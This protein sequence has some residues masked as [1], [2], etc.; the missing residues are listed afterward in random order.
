MAHIGPRSF[1][2]AVLTLV[3]LAGRPTHSNQGAAPIDVTITEGTSMAAAV[4]PDGE[5]VVID[6]QGSLWTLPSDGG[7]ATRIIDEFFDARQPSWSPDG[8]TIVFQSYRRGTWDIWAVRADGSDPTPLTGGAH[9]DREPHWS[10]DGRR[11]AFS[12]D[13]SGNYDLWMLD[14]ESGNLEQITWDPANDFAPAWSPDGQEIAFVSTRSSAPGIWAVTLGGTERLLATFD[15]TVNAPSWRPGT[16]EVAFNGVTGTTSALLLSDDRLTI[17]EDVF[18]FRASWL[19][20]DE[21]VYTADGLIKR[22]S[23][24]ADAPET[25]PFSASVTLDRSAYVRNHRDFDDRSPRQAFGIVK[26]VVS[27]DAEQVAFV[28]LGDLWLM[29]I[30]GRAERL[31]DD[32]FAE[33]DPAWSPDGRQL[34]F[35]SD[36]TGTMDLWVRDM[37]SGRERRLTDLPTA[38]VAAAWSPNGRLIAFK[39][40]DEAYYTV[41]VE[42]GNVAQVHAP[43]RR[44]GRP[45]WGPDGRTL[46]TTILEPYSSRY[47]EGTSQLLMMT[48]DGGDDRHVTAVP[49]RSVGKRTTDGPVWSPDGTMMALVMEGTLHVMA[50]SRRG[51]P[52]GPPRQLTDEV[53]DGPSWTGDSTRVLYQSADRLRMVSVNDGSVRDVPLD[54][55]WQPRAPTGRTVVH[56]GR[57]FDGRLDNLQTDVDIVIEAN[58]IRRVVPHRA[59][60]HDG[61]VIDASERTVMPGLI[62]MHTHLNPGFGEKLGR[63][64]LA[65]GITTVRIPAGSPYEAIESREAFAAGVRLGPRIYTTGYIF[66]GSRIFYNGSM[67][68]TAGPQLERELE[69]ARVMGYDLLKTYVRLPDLLQKRV[70][71]FGHRHGMPVT[72][73]ELYP[74]VAFGADGV[75]HIGGTSRR[76]YSPKRSSLGR[77]YGDVIELL[78]ASGM[79]ITPTIAIGGFQ[80]IAMRHPSL[81]ED[82]RFETL[83]P[84]WVVKSTRDSVEAARGSGLA[85]RQARTDA[86]AET[87]LALTRAGARIVAGTD[88]PIM[89]YAV[90]LHTELEHFVDGGL[91]PFQALQTATVNAAEALGS[92]LDLGSVEPGKLADLVFVDGDPLTDITDA[93]KVT[94]V[95]KNGELLELESLLGTPSSAR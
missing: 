54:L 17:G 68:L 59:A 53:A 62:E 61:D 31:T 3:V 19:S 65:Y 91:T 73:H 26:P 51:E 4:S 21:L 43:L 45:T 72:S 94:A 6:L 64:F 16:S 8:A 81:L 13:R 24:G 76:G 74:A 52:L 46:A 15:G 5:T 47:R 49:H 12:S 50:V 84:A 79:T 75:E 25:I 93:R 40:N 32:P 20:E 36:R 66:D 35:S 41:T 71:E 14:V 33:L 56:A 92:G 37:A 88:S 39:D 78:A 2:I 1:G 48:T 90:S 10:P 23:V 7:R 89:P 60:L 57:L 69:R 95:M 58:R 22:R 55:S 63:I 82:E 67:G 27:P 86:Q 83:F 9:D 30:G 18:P 80:L 85:A 28:A 44:S 38:E 70:V 87:V 77:S 29:P 42:A 11:I 34:A